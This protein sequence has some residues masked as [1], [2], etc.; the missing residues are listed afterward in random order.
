MKAWPPSWRSV[1]PN[2][3]ELKGSFRRAFDAGLLGLYL[4][5]HRDQR[6]GG[7][8]PR[9]RYRSLVDEGHRTSARAAVRG[10]QHLVLVTGRGAGRGL[11][12]CADDPQR[13]RRRCRRPR[14]SG[15]ARVPFRTRWAR[16]ARRTG[17]G[18]FARWTCDAGF[19]FWSWAALATTRQSE[20]E[21]D[22]KRN[23]LGS[24]HDGAR[25]GGATMCCCGLWRKACR[26]IHARRRE[27]APA[28]FSPGPALPWALG[29]QWG[30]PGTP[31]DYGPAGGLVP[32]LDEP[33]ECPSTA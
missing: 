8:T 23:I 28:R 6:A 15:R 12:A 16:R 26:A 21:R 1:V 2:I 20:G 4:G 5:A 22:E 3:P 11:A 13:P 10:D 30:L 14:R 31:Q 29:G 24:I 25:S 18:L 17:V 7:R 33:P 32:A 19:S 27:E 9:T